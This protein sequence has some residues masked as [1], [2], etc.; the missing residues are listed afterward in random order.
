[1]GAW[2]KVETETAGKVYAGK[3]RVEGGII[4]V[5]YDGEGGHDKSAKVGTADPDRLAK[6]MLSELVVN[7]EST[8]ASTPL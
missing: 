3:Y 5:I 4:T 8:G 1:M 2:N 6:A 7:R